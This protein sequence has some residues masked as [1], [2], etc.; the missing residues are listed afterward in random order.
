MK[1]VARRVSDKAMLHLIKEW[2]EA[3][4]EEANERGNHRRTTRPT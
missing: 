3:P 1:S 4:V 2:L